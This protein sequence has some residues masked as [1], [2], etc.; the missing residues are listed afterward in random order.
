[1]M[2]TVTT[3]PGSALPAA[4]VFRRHEQDAVLAPQ[5]A[6]Q[7]LMHVLEHFH[8]FAFW[9][10]PTVGA[11]D[12]RH[13]AVAVQH[14]AH[15]LFPQEK[16]RAALVVAHQK[17]ET[18]GMPLHAAAQQVEFLQD[19][20]VAAPV[21]H[22]L[23]IALHRGQ[24]LA[25]RFAVR[26]GDA[27]QAFEFLFGNRHAA[28]GQRFQDELPAR[29]RVLVAARLPL[30]VRVARFV[31]PG[32]SSASFSSSIHLIRVGGSARISPAQAQV[33]E[34]V[35]A[36]GSGPGASNGVGVRIPSWAPLTSVEF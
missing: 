3:W 26:G 23:A 1:M 4:F 34:L 33:A 22:D 15:L 13:H 25:E 21:A 8:D 28:P 16:V 27:Q 32:G 11:G 30:E 5:A 7:A 2:S 9:T 29:H 17:A 6:H 24:A 35:D 31:R 36:P 12:A 20:N 10:A 14:L 19:A 18:V